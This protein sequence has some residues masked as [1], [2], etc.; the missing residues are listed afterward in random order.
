[1][2]QFHDQTECYNGGGGGHTFQ[3]CG[4]EDHFLYVCLM[5]SNS[6]GLCMIYTVSQKNIP[7]VF[8]YNSRKH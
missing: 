4:V 5:S 3:R 2:T 8:S 7:D 1:M 6:T